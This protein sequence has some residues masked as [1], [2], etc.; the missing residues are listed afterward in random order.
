LG[1][2]PKH[3]PGSDRIVAVDRE[4]GLKGVADGDEPGPRPAAELSTHP[5]LREVER[6]EDAVRIPGNGTRVL[7]PDTGKL[8][9]KDAAVARGPRQRRPILLRTLV[10]I[11]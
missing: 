4:V 7:R 9:K 5:L 1:Q 2:T 8:R 10:P 11:L 3:L 6:I